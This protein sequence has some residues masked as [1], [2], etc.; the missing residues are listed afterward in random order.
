MVDRARRRVTV[1]AAGE[2]GERHVHAEFLGRFV[3]STNKELSGLVRR[4]KFREDLYT[5]VNVLR[6]VMPPLRRILREAPDERKHDGSR[7]RRAPSSGRARGL[8]PRVARRLRG[9]GGGAAFRCPMRPS[10][11]R[12]AAAPRRRRGPP[13]LRGGVD[14][15]DRACAEGHGSSSSNPVQNARSGEAA[16]RR[17]NCSCASRFSARARRLAE[18]VFALRRGQ[19]WVERQRWTRRRRQVGQHADEP[20][21]QCPRRLPRGR[22]DERRAR[23]RRAYPEYTTAGVS[24]S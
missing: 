20:A 2:L 3:F 12:S 19:R 10:P 8:R 13:A 14:A 4:G 16:A 18:Q 21:A 23:G 7:S 9:A 22:R 24:A 6:I 11:A 17:L 15:D 5:R 1:L